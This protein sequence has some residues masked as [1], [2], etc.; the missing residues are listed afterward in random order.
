MSWA[1]DWTLGTSVT[2]LHCAL[3]CCDIISPSVQFKIVGAWRQRAVCARCLICLVWVNIFHVQQ[4]VRAG[5]SAV[6]RMC[7]ARCA[8]RTADWQWKKPGGALCFWPSHTYYEPV[9]EGKEGW[10]DAPHMVPK[11]PKVSTPPKY[12]SRT[13]FSTSTNWND[14]CCL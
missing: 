11:A 5:C 7:D 3:L 2:A 10:G 12:F 8:D 13:L 9:E 4:A 1:P 6:R 14:L